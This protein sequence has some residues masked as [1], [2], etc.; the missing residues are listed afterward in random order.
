MR[1]LTTNHPPAHHCLQGRGLLILFPL[2]H[3]PPAP[4]L[5]LFLIPSPFPLFWL[6]QRGRWRIKWTGRFL[7]ACSYQSFVIST[8]NGVQKL[9]SQEVPF[10]AFWGITQHWEHFQITFHTRTRK[11]KCMRCLKQVGHIPGNKKTS[12]FLSHHSFKIYSGEDVL[13]LLLDEN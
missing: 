3:S 5:L 10:L 11:Y 4:H 7:L 9:L 2:L 8:L 12:L 1:F 13:S 6:D